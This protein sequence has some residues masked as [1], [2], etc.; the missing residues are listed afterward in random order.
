MADS[1]A[2][3]ESA[4]GVVRAE[5]GP[6]ADA[7]GSEDITAFVQELLTQMQSRFQTMSETIISK[8]DAMGGRIDELERTVA[9]LMD[10]AAADD[11]DDAAAGRGSA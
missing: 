10:Q 9:D 2:S 7:A 8:I 1:K 6:A 5:P 11:E 4:A 3:G